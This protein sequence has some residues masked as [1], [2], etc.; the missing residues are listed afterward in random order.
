MDLIKKAIPIMAGGVANRMAGI[1]LGRQFPQV[2]EGYPSVAAGLAT[3]GLLLMVPK[4]G[5]QLF[6]GGVVQSL[7]RGL[8]VLREKNILG[9][10]GFSS[11]PGANASPEFYRDLSPD[12]PEMLPKPMMDGMGDFL[13]QSQVDSARQMGQLPREVEEMELI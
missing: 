8:S 5:S 6:T 3:S 9:T 10:Q 12:M 2:A 7:T 13:V 4:Y 11:Y 1:F